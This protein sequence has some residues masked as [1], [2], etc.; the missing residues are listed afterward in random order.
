MDFF[1]NYWTS[2][3]G[4]TASDRLINE[5]L[6]EITR[7]IARSKIEANQLQRTFQTQI[8]DL[9]PAK[10][11]AELAATVEQSDVARPGHLAG[12]AGPIRARLTLAHPNYIF[13]DFVNT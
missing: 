9:S 11:I 3:T 1:L 2:R 10:R 13:G 8:S 4:H 6:Q 5:I 7:E 12:S